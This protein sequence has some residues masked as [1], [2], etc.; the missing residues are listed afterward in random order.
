MHLAMNTAN[1]KL[2]GLTGSNVK[3]PSIQEV[4]SQA[5][6]SAIL[7]ALY[8]SDGAIQVPILIRIDPMDYECYDEGDFCLDSSMIMYN[9]GTVMNS[10]ARA[11]M[12]HG[13]QRVM[14]AA[15]CYRLLKMA[16]SLIEEECPEMLASA[17]ISHAFLIL[18][19]LLVHSLVALSNFL[20]L[21]LERH[22]HAQALRHC[23]GCIDWYQSLIPVCTYSCAA[24][25]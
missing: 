17:G 4:S 19:A 12:E 9:Y 13:E 8:A 10:S 16:N 7:H 18:R 3:P 5:N 23:L 22:I 20:S 1:K 11:I 15:K 2:A 25:A 14:V 6:P 24:S 21:D